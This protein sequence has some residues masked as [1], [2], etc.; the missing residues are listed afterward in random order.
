VTGITEYEPG[1]ARTGPGVW[2]PWMQEILDRIDLERGSHGRDPWNGVCFQEAIALVT[3]QPM[4]DRPICVA[5][6]YRDYGVKLND[7][8]PST[9]L[10]NT[11]KEFVPQIV[12]THP[13]DAK[14][15]PITGEEIEQKNKERRK[16]LDE[17]FKDLKLDGEDNWNEGRARYAKVLAEIG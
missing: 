3:G 2:E 4:S 9:E 17:A 11:L 6:P 10:R 16:A 15:K 1:D 12:N 8:A 5:Q 7:N 14:L 13:L